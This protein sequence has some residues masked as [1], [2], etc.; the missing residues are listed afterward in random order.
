[1]YFTNTQSMWSQNAHIIPIILNKNSV[2]VTYFALFEGATLFI[3]PPAF[4]VYLNKTLQNIPPVS[5]K[6]YLSI[7][8]KRNIHLTNM[9]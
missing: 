5:I 4:F 7:D 3:S 8:S 2:K 1:M 9:K 6:N